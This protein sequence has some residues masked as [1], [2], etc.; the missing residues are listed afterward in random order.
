[1]LHT[2][3][4]V[5]T[6]IHLHGL[7]FNTDCVVCIYMLSQV[8][9]CGIYFIQQR[10]PGIN[11]STLIIDISTDILCPDFLVYWYNALM[12]PVQILK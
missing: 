5:H 6:C 8:S 2:K 1:M 11:K 10:A 4:N 9:I 3:Y 12:R 7:A